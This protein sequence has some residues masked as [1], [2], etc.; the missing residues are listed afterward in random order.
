MRPNLVASSWNF[1][2]FQSDELG[3]VSFI[4]MEFTTTDAHGRTG[5]GSGYVTTNVGSLVIND[6]LVSVS[7]ETKWPGEKSSTALYSRAEH[8]ETH[9]DPDTSYKPPRILS[10][11]FDGQTLDKE[12]LNASLEVDVGT[13][14]APKGLIQK[15]DVLAEIPYVLRKFVNVVAGTK[16]YIYQWNN[17]GVLSVSGPTSL[18]GSGK[19]EIKGI[20]YNEA[21]YLSK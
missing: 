13:Q 5:S 17:P 15:V 18:L 20:C 2:D 12:S 1:L 7:G 16:P 4:Q 9:Y 14:D 8:K 3:G 10:F 21:T 6:K 11:T 19:A